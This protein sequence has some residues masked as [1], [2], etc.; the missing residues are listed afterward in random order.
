MTT[1]C[2][3]PNAFGVRRLYDF[4]R[5]VDRANATRR[6]RVESRRVESIEHRDATE[7]AARVEEDDVDVDVRLD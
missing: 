1:K 5:R 4:E 2:D 6:E 3:A 7:G